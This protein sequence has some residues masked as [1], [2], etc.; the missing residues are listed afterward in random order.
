VIAA[1]PPRR[2]VRNGNRRAGRCPQSRRPS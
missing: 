1:P 2:D